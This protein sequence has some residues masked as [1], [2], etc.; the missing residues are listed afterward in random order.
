MQ[1]LLQK[2]AFEALQLQKDDKHKRISGQIELIQQE[3]QQLTLVE[4]E[5]KALR[6][7]SEIVRK[8]LSG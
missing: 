7:E 4:I 3:L 1:E 8:R 6:M 5:K 2:K